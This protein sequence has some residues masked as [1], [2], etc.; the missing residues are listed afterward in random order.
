M[1][2]GGVPGASRGFRAPKNDF[3]LFLDPSGGVLGPVL[4]PKLGAKS[5]LF[6]SCFFQ[7]ALQEAPRRTF[8]DVKTVS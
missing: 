6:C 8:G 4:V 5:L 7:E 3:S 2:L 1:G